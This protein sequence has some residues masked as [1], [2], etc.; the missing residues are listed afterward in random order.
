MWS[1]LVSI[2]LVFKHLFTR[3]ETVQYPEEMPYLAPRY[4]GR[5]D[6]ARMSRGGTDVDVNVNVN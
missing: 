1:Q 2:A 3:T 4:R 5:R 6:Q